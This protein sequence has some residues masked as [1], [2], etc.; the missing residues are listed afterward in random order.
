M[1]TAGERGAAGVL[2]ERLA[3]GCG[4]G[5]RR[6]AASNDGRRR[7]SGRGGGRSDALLDEVAGGGRG[8]TG[9]EAEQGVEGRGG[10][11]AAVPAEDELVE[12]ALQVLAA[13]AVEGPEPPALEVREDAVRPA[14]HDMGGH[15]AHDLR[16]VRVIG[17]AGV[18][19]PSSVTTRAPGAATAATNGLSVAAEKSAIGARRMRRGWPSG[20][21]STAPATNILPC[22]LRP[23]PP[24]G[25]SSLRRRGISVSSISTTPSSRPRPGSTMARRSFCSRSH[26][27]L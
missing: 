4:V 3:A 6:R 9:A 1:T 20:E 22:G 24:A 26:P 13:Q 27:L 12:V 11:P 16:V 10:M 5:R 21:S 18:A 7:L 8:E 25:G 19:G 14:Q 23:R 15:L 2:D 17:Q